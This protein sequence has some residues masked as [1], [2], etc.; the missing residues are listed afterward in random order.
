MVAL[1]VKSPSANIGNVRDVG[2]IPGSGRSPG[3]GHGKP[4]QY[5]CL[6]N[7]MD[8]GAWQAAAHRVTQSRT[9]LSDWTELTPSK[10][11]IL[12]IHS[13]E[14]FS[15]SLAGKESLCNSGDIKNHRLD[16]WV[17][18]IPWR[19]AW[20]PTP[21]FLSGESHGQRSL[22]VCGVEKSQIQLSDF[23]FTFHIYIY[24]YTSLSLFT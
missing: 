14:G 18:K 9:R 16:P 6:A 3:G 1:V 24:T 22:A 11:H 10:Y 17:G 5:S 15:D 8:R 12:W 7:P 20:Q 19:R 13:T 21:V 4:L 2:L 23:T